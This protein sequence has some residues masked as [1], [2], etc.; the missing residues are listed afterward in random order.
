MRLRRR[1]W[2]VLA[3]LLALALLALVN[4]KRVQVSGASM[5]PTF[6]DG[7]RVIVWKRAP[8]D[9]LKPGDIIVFQSGQGGGELIKRIVWV[10]SATASAH[11]PPPDFPQTIP[12]PTGTL[13]QD[14]G[15]EPY[16]ASV[17]AGAVPMPPPQNTIY[18][19]G[20]NYKHSLDS[21][22]FGPIDPG[23]ILGKVIH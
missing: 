23:Q 6:H 15:F 2:A 8:H 19:M 14:Y 10:A 11:F 7:D 16:F 13:D 9:Q 1:E 5:E 3:V 4:F 17:D 22:D 18:V 21:R 12:T 20:D